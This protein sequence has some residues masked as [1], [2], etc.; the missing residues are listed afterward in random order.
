MKKENNTSGSQRR[1]IQIVQIKTT[2]KVVPSK[3][4]FKR[5]PRN[6]RDHESN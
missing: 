6:N 2:E 4:V 3:K 5:K 1:D